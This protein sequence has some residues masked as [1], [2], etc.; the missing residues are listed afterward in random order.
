M[1][2][3]YVIYPVQDIKHGEVREC[4]RHLVNYTALISVLGVFSHFAD[5]VYFEQIT[6]PYINVLP[7]SDSGKMCFLMLKIKLFF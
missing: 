7:F 6:V 3:A 4:E 2:V 1:A 5:S